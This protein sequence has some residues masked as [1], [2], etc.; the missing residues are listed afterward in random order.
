MQIQYDAFLLYNVI[1]EFNW[2]AS[3]ISNKH[4]CFNLS[5][6]H[7][8]F[9]YLFIIVTGDCSVYDLL[10]HH[11]EN[12]IPYT[13]VHMYTRVRAGAKRAVNQVKL[14]RKLNTKSTKI[15]DALIILH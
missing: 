9:I 5:L 15:H 13:H 4:C 3:S 1:M 12:C 10:F 7:Y 11:R 14:R 6:I 8:L 2:L